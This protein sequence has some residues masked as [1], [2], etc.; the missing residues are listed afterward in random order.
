MIMAVLAG[1]YFSPTKLFRALPN[2]GLK[3]SGK[4]RLVFANAGF[5]RTVDANFG[6][7]RASRKHRGGR[8]AATAKRCA[9]SARIDSYFT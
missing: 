3:D 9:A 5:R 4:P 2:R 1:L 8:M 7:M 6:L